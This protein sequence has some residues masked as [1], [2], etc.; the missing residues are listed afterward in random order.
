MKNYINN[1]K[2][3]VIINIVLVLFIFILFV[4]STFL[5]FLMNDMKKIKISA[6]IEEKT[7]VEI[8]SDILKPYIVESEGVKITVPD[9]LM[10]E[11]SWI[12]NTNS[13]PIRIRVVKFSGLD[14]GEE[15]LSISRLEPKEKRNFGK[16]IFT[17]G[18]YI[19]TID[20]IMIGWLRI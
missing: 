6:D 1:Q 8:K 16:T 3:S 7:K 14:V 9:I 12:E 13:F 10:K 4:I 15:T 18:Y 2:G 19:Y 11:D 17:R 5:F 20:G